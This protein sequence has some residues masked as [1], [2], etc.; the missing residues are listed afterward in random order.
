MADIRRARAGRDLG[1]G[2]AATRA[3]AVAVPGRVPRAR[4][5]ALSAALP[6]DN[7]YTQY[8]HVN[9]NAENFLTFNSR[10]EA[11]SQPHNLTLNGA[12]GT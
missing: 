8:L 9:I 6:F 7:R 2:A 12:F 1:I 10:N 5:R 4:A 11:F 3:I